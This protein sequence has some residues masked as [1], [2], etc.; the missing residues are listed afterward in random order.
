MSGAARP[1]VASIVLSAVLAITCAQ[2]FADTRTGAPS[3][4]PDHAASNVLRPPP[5]AECKAGSVNANDA[6][7]AACRSAANGTASRTKRAQAFSTLCAMLSSRFRQDEAL[8]ACNRA[9][10]LDPRLA[11]AWL[12]RARADRSIDDFDTAIADFTKAIALDKK[13]AVDVLERGETY[14]RMGDYD[15]LLP[16]R[17]STRLASYDHAIADGQSVKAL[18]HKY[19]PKQQ[20]LGGVISR[21]ADELIDEVT[22]EKPLLAAGEKPADPHLWCAGKDLPEGVRGPPHIEDSDYIEMACTAVIRSGHETNAMLGEAYFSRAR[23]ADEGNAGIEDQWRGP[24]SIPDY[25]K[26][27]SLGVKIPEASFRI[28]SLYA[29]DGDGQKALSYLDV[30]VAAGGPELEQALAA[31]AQARAETGQYDGAMADV[32]HAVALAPGDPDA[33][34]ASGLAHVVHGDY[35]L[36]LADCSQAS[37]TGLAKGLYRLA[38]RADGVCGNAHYLKKDY[39]AAISDYEQAAKIA[40]LT[41]DIVYARGAAK[42]RNGDVAGAQADVD[43]AFGMDS[44]AAAREAKLGIAP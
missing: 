18:A 19:P 33:L 15:R 38:A 2:S 10:A 30:A 8:S 9:I 25:E 11:D 17:A 24:L 44:N 36:A 35:D 7:I 23:A 12:N 26:A 28:G 27:I 3:M 16:G 22:K 34:L 4:G 21:W 14:Q 20:M 32:V 13:P 29:A 37:K 6:Q 31:R 40:P 43:Q 41:A 39:P 42:F 5:V 1:A